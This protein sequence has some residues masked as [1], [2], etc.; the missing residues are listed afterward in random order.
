MKGFVLLLTCFFLLSCSSINDILH[1]TECFD[2]ES[3][4]Q[5]IG[6]ELFQHGFNNKVSYW[7]TG[8]SN[9]RI[10]GLGLQ[11]GGFDPKP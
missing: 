4:A 1:H 10:P 9:N 3:D 2:T 6:D 7:L 5:R 8:D 11:Y